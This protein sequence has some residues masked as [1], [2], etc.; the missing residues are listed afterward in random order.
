[1]TDD[2]SLDIVPIYAFNRAHLVMGGER[3]IVMVS[4]LA[5]LILIVIL[6]NVY[7]AV[8]GVI[9][10]FVMLGIAR[11]MAKSDP[12][13]TKVYKRFTRYQR[14]YPAHTTKYL[15]KR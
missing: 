4:M 11:S 1:M 10:Q 14:F 13:L 9:L 12:I 15:V 3:E 5:A 2:E 7:T 6:Q 8:L